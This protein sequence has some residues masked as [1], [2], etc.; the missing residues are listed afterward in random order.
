MWIC[1]N[2]CVQKISLE[3]TQTWPFFFGSSPDKFF[4]KCNLN[5]N[6]NLKLNNCK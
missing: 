5:D 4:L 6:F 3:G 2:L 1:P